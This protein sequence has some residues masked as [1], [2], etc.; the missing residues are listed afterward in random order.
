MNLEQSDILH[1]IQQNKDHRNFIM[2]IEPELSMLFVLSLVKACVLQE[3]AKHITFLD[4]I[5]RAL[6]NEKGDL[7]IGTRNCNSV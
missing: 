4:N 2:G 7:Y 6:L 1:F 5:L 3:T